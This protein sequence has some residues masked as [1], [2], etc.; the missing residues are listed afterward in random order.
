VDG[1]H[2]KVRLEQE[3]LCLL[4]MIGVRT[5]G[6]KELVALADGYRESTESWA[7]LL[8]DCRRRGMTAP[9]LAVGDGA[10]GFAAALREVFPQPESSDAGGTSRPTSLPRCR[11]Q[12]IRVHWQR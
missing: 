9:V 5:D 6:R 10:L 4:V 12:H 2:L 7:D 8:R 3:K 11:N 1:I